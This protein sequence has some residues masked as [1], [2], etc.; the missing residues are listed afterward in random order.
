MPDPAS[1]LLFQR[2]TPILNRVALRAFAQRLALEVAEGRE[3]T[4]LFGGDI[5]LRRLNRD[6]LGKD[7]A[8]DVLS[9]PSGSAAGSLGDLAISVERAEA[10]AA[11]FGHTVEDEICV[12]MLHGVLHLTGEDHEA[13][14]GQMQRLESRWRSHFGLPAGLIERVRS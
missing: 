4:C 11:E 7:F 1:T 14:S 10:Q 8:T 9:F 3:F 12:L 5:K 6:F 13:D 2:R